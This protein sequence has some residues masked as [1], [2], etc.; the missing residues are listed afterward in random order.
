MPCPATLGLTLETI[1]DAKQEPGLLL[2]IGQKAAWPRPKPADALA[3][4]KI[5]DRVGDGTGDQPAERGEH[6]PE[7]PHGFARRQNPAPPGVWSSVLQ[8]H[9]GVKGIRVEAVVQIDGPRHLVLNG[10]EATGAMRVM[11]QHELYASGTE[12]TK[13]IENDERARVVEGGNGGVVSIA[14]AFGRRGGHAGLHGWGVVS[15]RQLP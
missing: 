4:N 12:H 10:R 13:T 9:E 15:R 1:L 5:I 7:R 11:L 14:V 3:L 6:F 2:I 8:H